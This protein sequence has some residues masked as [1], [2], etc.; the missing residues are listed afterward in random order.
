MLAVS[1]DDCPLQYQCESATDFDLF[2]RSVRLYFHW[3]M[4]DFRLCDNS[5][6][7]LCGAENAENPGLFQVDNDLMYFNINDFEDVV[8]GPLLWDV[9]RITVSVLLVAAKCSVSGAELFL[10]SCYVLAIN[11]AALAG[12][13]AYWSERK[14][15]A[16]VAKQ[17]VNKVEDRR[18]R[19]LLHLWALQEGGGNLLQILVQ[20]SLDSLAQS[21]VLLAVAAWR[22][23]HLAPPSGSVAHEVQGMVGE[24]SLG[25]PLDDI[26]LEILIPHI[27]SKLLDLKLASLPAAGPGVGGPQSAWGSEADCVVRAQRWLQAV[28]P[29]LLLS[30]MLYG[31]SLVMRKLKLAADKLE[32]VSTP[33]HKAGFRISVPQ[34][35]QM[36]AWAHL[37]AAN[38]VC[39]ADPDALQSFGSADNGCRVVVLRSAPRAAA[40]IQVDHRDF[41]ASCHCGEIPLLPFS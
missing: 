30:L 41:S 9:G 18:P 29:V 27:S 40:Q 10:Q 8:N 20:H 36:L 35:A 7:W 17:L 14:T 34:V 37:R 23:V 21:K 16:G 24:G 5:T 39:A 22:R 12:G 11:T 31:Q 26:M 4:T 15:V 32:F 13:K 3:F 6:A 38:N 25:V 33:Y 19:A 2:R 28:P 1:R